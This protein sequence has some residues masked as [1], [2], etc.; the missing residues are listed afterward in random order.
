MAIEAIDLFCGAGGLTYG[1]RKA[2]VDVRLGIDLD[3]ACAYPFSANNKSEF[4][5][6]DV[7]QVTGSDLAR[8]YSP[9]AV[10]LLAGCAPCQPFSTLRHGE[11]TSADA[12][13]SLLL[14]F[15][16]L[17]RELAPELVTMENVPGVSN[18][19]PYA[20]FTS[21]LRSM[22]YS[23]DTA[24]VNCGNYGLAQHRKRF[25]LVASRLGRMSVPTG[26]KSRRRTVREV[27][28]GLPHVAAGQRDAND[29]LH[30]AK[31]LTPI[32]LA[33]VMASKPNGTWLDWPE[34]LRL[35]CHKKESGS[36][37]KS[38]YGR[39]GWDGQSPTITTQ[40][41]NLG[42]GR[43]THPEQHRAL[44]L[45]EAAMLQSFPKSYKFA[46]A[47]DENSFSV[48]GRL[49]GNAVPPALGKALGEAF[50]QHVASANGAQ[51]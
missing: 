45:R 9:G 41:N 25:V 28:G 18:H 4:L 38:V 7:A 47:D 40:A 31:A 29:P 46:K 13:W 42:T 39:M 16:R 3:P 44:T 14:H 33:R 34:H 15:G 6:Q 32:N 2:G 50:V 12:K 37:F 27:I 49:I 21:A 48:V 35:A 26:D 11:D 1:L 36:T 24:I 30:K 19:I 8:H 51:A 22:G 23:F 20:R 5:E 10:R 43:F 17:I